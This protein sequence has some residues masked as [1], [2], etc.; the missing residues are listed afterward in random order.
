MTP[1]PFKRLLVAIGLVLLS[2]C[3][4]FTADPTVELHHL[5]LAR[6]KNWNVHSFRMKL[7]NHADKPVWF[8]LPA[9]GDEPRLEN[10]I[11]RS[12][13]GQPYRLIFNGEGKMAA[14]GVAFCGFGAVRIPARTVLE[15]P[16]Y[17]LSTHKVVTT[18]FIET[19][20]VETEK[21]LVNGEIPLEKW[22][23]FDV[24]VF[25]EEELPSGVGKKA[26]LEGERAT[27]RKEHP[28]EEVK[29]VEAKGVRRWT[30]KFQNNGEKR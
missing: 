26:K 10:T 24:G 29:Y 9:S 15:I 6:D 13:G 16:E 2:A 1:D 8:L 28:V 14:V 4:A 12:C 27:D 18:D 21:L 19:M 20:F 17:N 7:S 11:F 3:V 5:G 22:L 23:P 25:N 30:V